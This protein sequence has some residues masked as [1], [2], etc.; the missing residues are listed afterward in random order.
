MPIQS[1]HK[2]PA[3]NVNYVALRRLI[4][5][6]GIAM[7]F[8]LIL[9]NR[10]HV[11]SSISHFYYTDMSVIFTGILIS[12]S[13]ILISYK[14]YPKEDGEWLS[15]NLIT[16]LAG[17]CAFIVA[18]IPTA[19]GYCDTGVPNAH[20]NHI[21]DTVHLIAAGLFITMMGYMSFVQFTKGEVENKSDKIRQ[22]IYKVCGLL[23]W[24]VVLLLLVL[25]LADYWPFS[26]VIFWAESIALV[27]FGVSWL[28]KSKALAEI[29]ILQTT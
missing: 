22:T 29:G 1:D 3:I 2:D 24:F 16:N 20:D 6:L 7:P 8:L 27:S 21:K 10:G 11:E 12:F 18:F 26:T 15:D 23:I 5:V 9:G 14:G 4:G 13:L 19:C 17:V 25:V 28:V